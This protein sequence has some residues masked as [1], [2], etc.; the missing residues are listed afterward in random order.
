MA[1]RGVGLTKL[2]FA[3]HNTPLANDRT[4]GQWDWNAQPLNI[5]CSFALK[6]ALKS[7][8]N[9]LY[10][11][12]G[13]KTILDSG[14]YSAWKTGTPTEV[15]DLMVEAEGNEWDEVASPSM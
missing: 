4:F 9:R 1:S 6:G 5:L 15:E 10:E 13:V 14:A 3:L 7:W 11:T 2:Y 12:P 8:K